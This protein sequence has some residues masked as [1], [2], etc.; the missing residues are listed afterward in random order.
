MV[1]IFDAF[2]E[3]FDRHRLFGESSRPPSRTPSQERIIKI[4]RQI[5]QPQLDEYAKYKDQS[6]SIFNPKNRER[7]VHYKAERFYLLDRDLRKCGYCHDDSEQGALQPDHIIPYR[8]VPINHMDNLVMACGDCNNGKSGRVISRPALL[9]IL[10]EVREKN[11]AYFPFK[12]YNEYRKDLSKL[13][14]SRDFF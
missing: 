11:E 13:V 1:N 6:K 9:D 14:L 5:N 10:T 7:L 3:F 2:G 8:V 12:K 4:V